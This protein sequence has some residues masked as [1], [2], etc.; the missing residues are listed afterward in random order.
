[1]L[2]S[3]D[4]SPYSQVAI[5]PVRADVHQRLEIS[6]PFPGNFPVLS[7]SCHARWPL[8]RLPA[9][10]PRMRKN[11]AMTPTSSAV[12]VGSMLI[13]IP[14]PALIER[15]PASPVRYVLTELIGTSGKAACFMGRAYHL[16]K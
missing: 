3:S 12:L 8:L 9:H 15:I 14:R 6:R 1:M 16:L 13:G 10:C 2:P 11:S 4:F 5:L 7:D